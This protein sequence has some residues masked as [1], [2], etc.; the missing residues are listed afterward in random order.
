ML[1]AENL[2]LLR[3]GSIYIHRE[4]K[5]RT[6]LF[7][8]LDSKS[9]QLLS[10]LSLVVVVRSFAHDRDEACMGALQE[11]LSEELT[12]KFPLPGLEPGSLG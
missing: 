2:F 7:I 9:L 3:T 10:Q 12:K 8:L 11:F 4:G 5:L 6:I 1:L